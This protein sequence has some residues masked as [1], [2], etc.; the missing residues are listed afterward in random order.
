VLLLAGNYVPGGDPKMLPVRLV[1]FKVDGESV[2]LSVEVMT[3][4]QR[5]AWIQRLRGPYGTPTANGQ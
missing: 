2:T 4:A 3:A 1:G 5:E